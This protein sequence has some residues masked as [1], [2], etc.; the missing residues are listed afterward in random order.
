MMVGPEHDVRRA[1]GRDHF[2]GVLVPCRERLLAQ[3]VPPRA[4]RGQHLLA[5]QF[6]GGG[7]VHGVD[8]LQQRR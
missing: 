2:G 8:V 6:V 3:H 5:V 7:D 1:A 4:R